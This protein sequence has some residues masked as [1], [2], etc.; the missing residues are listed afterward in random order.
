MKK[1]A[2]T[3]T[4]FEREV[5]S[6]DEARKRFANNQYKCELIEEIF[7]KGEEITLYTSGLFTDLCRGGHVD[8]FSSINMDAWQLDGIAGAYWRG[9]ETRPMLTRIYGLAFDTKEELDTYVTQREE[10]KLR[11]HKKIGKELELFVFSDRVG[12]GLPLFLPKGNTI[13][14]VLEKFVREE[15]EKL[16]Y[17][18]VSIPHIAK[19]DLYETSGHMGKYDAMMPIMTDQNGETYVMKAMNCPHHFE[20]YNSQPHSYRDLPLRLAENTSVYRNEKSGELSGLLRVKSL[21]QDDTHHFVR[22]DQI[23]EEIDMILDLMVKVYK[24]FDFSDYKIE[25]SVRDQKNTSAYFGD[26]ELW[27]KAEK[28]LIES[29]EKN[30]FSYS[31][32]EGE[33]AF[34]GPKIDV[35][36]KDAIGRSWQ[37]T[38]VQLDFNQPEN[39]DM[40]YIGKDG[41]KNRVVVLHVAILGSLERFLGVIIEH[42]A[43]HFPLWLAP[44]QIAVVPIKKDIH[45]KYAQAIADD[46]KKNGVR[47]E[48]WD[49]DYNNFGKKIRRAKNEKIPY[50]IVIG[51]EEV[52]SNTITVESKDK[53]EKGISL[54]SFIESIQD[55]IR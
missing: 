50:W 21:M 43:G 19:T 28:K 31:I 13:K 20:I 5:V 23:E 17:K 27:E 55:I 2:K 35:Q 39:F 29:V 6:V 1:I 4:P 47:V 22:E 8:D 30:N 54:D 51:D 12:K 48:L 9:D 33:A 26:D 25:I 36:V 34:Y 32:E 46:L 42:Y 16:G 14:E 40:N 24:R 45:G 37:L 44:T 10:A 38:T 11:D 15:K 3:W 52:N 53:Q 49:E 41:K 7:E 18:F